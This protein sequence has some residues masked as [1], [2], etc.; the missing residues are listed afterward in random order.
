MIQCTS[1]AQKSLEAPKTVSLQKMFQNKTAVQISKFLI[2]GLLCF[3]VEVYAFYILKSL[4]SLISANLLA[5]I[6]A[7][8]LHFILLKYYVFYNSSKRLKSIV[9]YTT[10]S[11]FN[12]FFSGVLIYLFSQHLFSMHVVIYKIIFDISL[13]GANYFILKFYVFK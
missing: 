8:F 12:S 5:R 1:I 2:F 10:L 13:I 6:L 11:I 4:F 9:L 3:I 7:L